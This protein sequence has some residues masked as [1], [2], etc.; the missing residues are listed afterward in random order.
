M[1]IAY[2][3]C[4]YIIIHFYGLAYLS[5]YLTTQITHYLYIRFK[6]YFSMNTGIQAQDLINETYNYK[7]YN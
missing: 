2:D 7:R 3:L 1:Q 6:S 4:K 5:S